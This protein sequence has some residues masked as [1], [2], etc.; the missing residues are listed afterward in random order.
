VGR[1]HREITSSQ[2]IKT[3]CTG[4]HEI[5]EFLGSLENIHREVRRSKEFV[6][7]LQ[8]TFARLAVNLPS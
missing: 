4:D 8:V 1:I 6:R 2:E 7:S 3:T 5:K